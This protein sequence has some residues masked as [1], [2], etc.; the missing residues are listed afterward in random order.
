MAT[1]TVTIGLNSNRTLAPLPVRQR[2]KFVS[3]VRAALQRASAQVFVDGATSRGEWRDVATGLIVREQSRTWVASVEDV[4]AVRAALPDLAAT[5][6][7][8][9]IALTVGATE[10]AA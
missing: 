8:D 9:A 5:F 6:E 7:Q 2:R 4:S 1:V 3:A 10:L